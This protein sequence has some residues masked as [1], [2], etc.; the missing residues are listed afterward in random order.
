MNDL[1]ILFGDF[2]SALPTYLLNGVLVTFYWLT[3]SAPAIISIACAVAMVQFADL[4]IQNRAM[5]RPARQ[6]REMAAPDPHTAQV[7]TGI[8]LGLWLLSQWSMG[9]PVPWIGAA[10]W[11]FGIIVLLVVRQQQLTTLW[12]IK[13]GLAIYALAVIGSRLYLTYTAELS[14][15]QWSALIGS[16]DSAATVLSNTRGNV[17]TIILWALWLVIPLGYFAML[18]QQVLLNPVSLSSPMAAVHELIDRYRVR[19]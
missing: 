10:M 18:L 11:L 17:T 19:Q 7:L 16:A 4:K 8:V 6:G 14:A 9:A 13:S 15:E 5:F 2:L 3:D 1:S 12:N